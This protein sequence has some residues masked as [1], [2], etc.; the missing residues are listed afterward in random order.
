LD[1]SR[2]ALRE[3]PNLPLCCP[4]LSRLDASDN[5]I[6]VFPVVPKSLRFLDLSRN[7]I[8]SIPVDIVESNLKHLNLSFNL[9]EV[10]PEMPVSLRSLDLEGNALSA[11]QPLSA[12]TLSEAIFSRNCV[13]AFPGFECTR[14]PELKLDH[15]CFEIL[16]V[17]ECSQIITRLDLSFNLVVEV[18]FEIFTLPNLKD[19]DLSFN[20]I[21]RLPDG[22]SVPSLRSLNLTG[23]PLN[24][25]PPEL[26]STLE[27]LIVC[28]CGLSL[29]PDGYAGLPDLVEFD[30]SMNAIT[31]LP[32]FPRL[33]RLNMAGN[34]PSAFPPV[35]LGALRHLDLACDRLELLPAGAV[36]RP[37]AQPSHAPGAPE[38]PASPEPRPY[39]DHFFPASSPAP[40][41]SHGSAP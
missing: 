9:I 40:P 41:A 38:L 6:I 35:S 3:L 12:P 20:R 28:D 10:V 19:L 1:V 27:R 36:Y 32:P 33:W 17:S 11:V 25:L 14:L 4:C 22:I 23:N 21:E 24:A 26:S 13:P 39:G 34:A 7:R 8:P 2:N 29:V 15:N 16:E 18:P 31:S 5:D 30:A 37:L